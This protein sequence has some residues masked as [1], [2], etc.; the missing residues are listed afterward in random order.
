MKSCLRAGILPAL[1]A[2]V[3][4]IAPAAFAADSAPDTLVVPVEGVTVTGARGLETVLRSPAAVS[5]VPRDRLVST[6]RISLA[7]GLGAR[8]R[9]VRAEPRRRAGRAHHDPRLR[10]ARQR[11]A[12]ERRQHARHPR[13]DRRHPD[14][15]AR[16]PHLAR[17]RG[18]RRH[19]PGRGAAQQRLGALRQRLGRRGQPAHAT[20][21]RARRSSSCSARGGSFG[22]HREQAI[23]GFTVGRARAAGVALQLDV[24]RLARAQQRA[25]RRRSRAGCRR[26]ST[27]AR[28]SACCWTSSATSTAIPGAL[29][30]AQA[31]RRPG[32]G[33]PHVRVARRAALQPRRP[34]SGSRSTATLPGEQRLSL[35]ACVEPKVLQRSERNRFRDFTRYHVGGSATWQHAA[36][37]SED[38]NG[39]WTAGADEQFQDG[40]ILFYTLSPGGSRGTDLIANK[41]EGANSVGGFV[42]GEL[43]WNERW[44]AARRGALRQPL[45]HLRGPHRPA[46]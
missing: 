28:G 3:I 14:H 2:G 31:R 12:L 9:R 27:T 46:R 34:R 15:R 19:R 23:V 25:P 17:P 35:A 45:V 40:S 39:V 36:P 13:A 37:R 20:R 29:T 8:A 42:Q 10:R 30:Q 21:F 1:F 33:E 5:L 44:S 18:P 16:R 41:R 43:L 6:R 7:D 4:C 32:A 22:F 24:R 38:S 26:R 11:R